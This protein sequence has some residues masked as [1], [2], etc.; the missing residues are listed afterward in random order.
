MTQDEWRRA[1]VVRYL[2]TDVLDDVEGDRSLLVELSD[3]HK[4]PLEI[5]LHRNLM[6]SDL[7]NLARDL[8]AAHSAVAAERERII[9]A[10]ESERTGQYGM[11]DYDI[12]RAIE[13]V[14]GGEDETNK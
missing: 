1:A 9:A 3:E 14:K 10:L 13:I 7:V 5:Y 6:V 8:M 12:D 11:H 2:L 4:H